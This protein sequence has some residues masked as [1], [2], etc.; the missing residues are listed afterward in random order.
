ME[1]LSTNLAAFW[2]WLL[3]A[4]LQGSLLVCLIV[5]IKM[6]FRERLPARWHYALWLVL[7]LRLALPWA[8][9]SRIS[10]YSLISR[11]ASFHPV[12]LGVE[13]TGRSRDAVSK[14]G[15]SGQGGPAG[16]SVVASQAKIL[17]PVKGTDC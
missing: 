15:L 4:T 8:P 13:G 1:A 2:P 5:L 10:I 14:E 6:I 7:L 17:Q 16:S 9:Q 12:T 3:K 11:S